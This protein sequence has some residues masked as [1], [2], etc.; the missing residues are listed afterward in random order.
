MLPDAANLKV[1][2]AIA[3][4]PQVL[5]DIVHDPALDPT[6]CTLVQRQVGA[7]SGCKPPVIVSLLR[8]VDFPKQQEPHPRRLGSWKAIHRPAQPALDH[9]LNRNEISD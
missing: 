9:P 2:S 7:V 4:K 6:G 8:A 5:G 3:F 1:G